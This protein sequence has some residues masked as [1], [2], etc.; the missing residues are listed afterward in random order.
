MEE[1]NTKLEKLRIGDVIY[2]T[3]LNKMFKNRKPYE[4]PDSRKIISYIP[5]TIAEIQTKVGKKVKEGEI[6][7]LLE[8]MKMK[9]RVLAPYDGVIKAIHV[10]EGQVVAKNVLLLEIERQ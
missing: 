1:N 5:G 6:L 2:E 4:A 8:A 7:I 10:K 3:Q 9:N